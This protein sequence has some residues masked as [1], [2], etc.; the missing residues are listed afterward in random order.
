M[1]F[2][3]L[4]AVGIIFCAAASGRLL[5]GAVANAFPTGVA[6][7]IAGLPMFSGMNLRVPLFL[8]LL[9]VEHLLS[10]LAR[11]P[12]EEEPHPQLHL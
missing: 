5:G 9:A 11:P 1:G 7:S 8:C 12:G 4:T 3:S 2:D 6:Q 10:H